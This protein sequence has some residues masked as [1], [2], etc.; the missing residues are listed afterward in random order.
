MIS[1]N[2]PLSL[3]STAQYRALQLKDPVPR[4]DIPTTA[5]DSLSFSELL[6]SELASKTGN[7]MSSSTSSETGSLPTDETLSKNDKMDLALNSLIEMDCGLSLLLSRTKQDLISCKELVTFLKKRALIEEEYSRNL[8]KLTQSS[9]KN[10]ERGDGKRGTYL[11]SWCKFLKLHEVIADNRHIFATTINEI[12]DEIFNLQKEKE[13]SRKIIKENGIKDQKILHEA[14][15]SLQRSRIRYE[16]LSEEWEKIILMKDQS[17]NKTPIKKQRP[18][19]SIFR[20]TKMTDDWQKV[21]DDAKIKANQANDTYRHQLANTNSIRKNYFKNQLP[22]TLEG[23][24]S[25]GDEIDNALQYQMANYAYHFETALLNDAMTLRPKQDKDQ[26]LLWVIDQIDNEKDLHTFISENSTEANRVDKNQLS[27]SHYNLSPTAQSI[28]SPKTVFGVDLHE[29]L[30]RDNQQIPVIISKCISAIEERG[31][32]VEGIYRLSGF[33]S[34]I[35]KLRLLFDRDSETVDLNSPEWNQDI[36]N[37]TGVLKMFLREL[38]DSIFTSQLYPELLKALKM[39]NNEKKI[40]VLKSALG[41]LP[42]YNY[43]TLKALIFHLKKIESHSEI[44]MM[45]SSNLSIVFGPTLLGPMKNYD[46][47]AEMT[48]YCRI[49]EMILQHADALFKPS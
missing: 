29:Q 30:E 44:N 34:S 5:S 3:I 18:L 10:I 7:P 32:N 43:H 33:S 42:Q 40:A 1:Q 27:F 4:V 21:E 17:P 8:M 46:L 45:N 15:L 6:Y 14:E 25:V 12:G 47:K 24:K 16:N 19:S 11:D 31:L 37:I 9:F 38:P 22:E 39:E 36:N 35:R 41:Q 2:R 48:S 20:Q 49:V 28:V 13:K 26:S 23:L